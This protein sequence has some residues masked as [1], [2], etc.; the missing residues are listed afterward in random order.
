[1]K[2]WNNKCALFGLWDHNTPSLLTYFGLYAQQH[3]G[4]EGAG[5]VSFEKDKHF[6]HKGFGLVGDVFNESSFQQLKGRSAIGHT[7]YS[8]KGK[9]QD[10][11][12]LQPLLVNLKRGPLALA[13][14]GNLVNF[15]SLKK[16]LTADGAVFE[17]TGDTECI[18]HLLRQN[19]SSDLSLV[20]ILKKSLSFVEGAYCLLILTPHELVAVRDPRGFRPLV[21][22][23]IKN[24]S[25]AVTWITASETCAFDLLSAEYVREVKP[26]EIVSISS[27]AE[28]KSFFLDKKEERKA[29]VFEHIYFS[30]PDSFVFGASVYEKRKQMGRLLAEQAPAEADL[31]IPVPDSGTASALGYSQKSGIP[32]EMGIIR[33][34]YIGRTFIHPSPEVRNFSVRVKLNPQK[35]LIKG[36][37]VVVVDDSIVRGTTSRAIVKILRQAKAGEVHFRVSSPPVIGPCYYGVDTPE[38]SQLLSACK[39]LKEIKDFL[40]VDSIEFLSLENLNRIT[41]KPSEGYCSACFTGKYPTPT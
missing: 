32:F 16:K 41:K 9:S 20:D 22:G 27:S 25:G 17:G 23:K 19:E 14:N 33:N 5:I 34:H 1:M 30:R 15:T 2:Y 3:R 18:V 38:K 7:R 10:K 35:S 21:L 13:H 8:T 28:P 11:K 29:C 40:N 4:Q 12:S 24:E 37:R 36:K 39:N 26:G 31:V 6:S